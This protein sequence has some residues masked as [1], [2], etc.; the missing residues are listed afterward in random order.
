M[1]KRLFP[2]LAGLTLLA[3]CGG[4]GSGSTPAAYTGV[5]TQATVTTSNAKALSEDAYSGSQVSSAVSGLAKEATIGSGQQALLQEVATILENSATTI[6]GGSKSS[7]KAV[8][9]S[10]QAT[11]NGYSGSFTYSINY[12]QTAGSF[13]G[14]V[15]FSQY[16]E[17]STSATI[18]GTIGFSGVYNQAAGTFS[19]LS[20]TMSNMT[21][22]SGGGRTFAMDGSM[23]YSTA[24]TTKTVTMTVVLTDSASG[25]TYWI[26]NFTLTLVGNSLTV[27]GTYYDPVH[28]YVVISTVTPLTVAT[29]DAT[30]TSG[31]L[32]FTGSNGT[33]ARLTFTSGGHTVEADTAGN[34]TFVVVP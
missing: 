4:G 21:G 14:T 2:I 6:V 12:D 27:T 1:Y 9:A 32:L 17:T 5:T 26:K 8:D 28:G 11:I 24:G 7:A 34:G 10:A 18:S 3:G 20:I 33:K 25:R 16:R 22:S 15:S 13:S 30:P 23:A 19:S 29:M 31:Q